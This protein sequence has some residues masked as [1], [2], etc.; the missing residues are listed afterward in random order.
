MK[1]TTPNLMAADTGVQELTPPNSNG[2][3]IPTLSGVTGTWSFKLVLQSY[4]DSGTQDPVRIFA[5]LS[6]TLIFVDGDDYAIHGVK[7][8]NA[9]N[10]NA[11]VILPSTFTTNWG[12]T[13]QQWTATNGNPFLGSFMVLNSSLSVGA[14]AQRITSVTSES[15]TSA[16]YLNQLNWGDSP[17]DTDDGAIQVWDGSA[18]EYTDFSGDWQ[19][20]TITPP[21]PP[22][23][24]YSLT[25][26]LLKQYLDGQSFHVYKMNARITLSVNNKYNTDASGSRPKYINPI[27]RINDVDGKSYVFLRGTFT[28]GDDTWDGEWFN[29]GEDTPTITTTAVDL[30]MSDTPSREDVL[31]GMKLSGSNVGVRGISANLVITTLSER[32]AATDVVTNG[33][34]IG[35]TSWTKGSGVTIGDDQLKFESVASGIGALNATTVSVGIEYFVKFT[36]S[37]Y[38]SGGIQVKLGEALGTAVTANGDYTQNITATT[39]TTI[40]IIASE[41]DTTLNVDGI[42]I[43]ARTKSIKIEDIGETLLADGYKIALIEPVNGNIYD[44]T[45]D[46]AQ[47]SGDTSLTIEAYDFEYP[48]EEGAVITFDTKNLVKEYQDDTL[49]EVCDNGDTTT[50]D[51]KLN[52]GNLGIGTTSPSLPLHVVANE[53]KWVA[54]SSLMNWYLQPAANK[55]FNF[56]NLTQNADFQFKQ[57]VGGSAGTSTLVIK[58]DTGNVGIGTTAPTQKL[59]VNGYIAATRFINPASTLSYLQFDSQ[60]MKLRGTALIYLS[61]AGSEQFRVQDGK[62][63]IGTT[64]PLSELHIKN[65]SAISAAYNDAQLIIEGYDKSVLQMA[66][67]A[68]GY[69]QLVFGD[70]DDGNRGGFLYNNNGDYLVIETNNSEVIRI[71]SSLNVGIGTTDPASKIHINGAATLT[72]MAAPSDPAANDCVIWLD[73][74][75]LDLMVKIKGEA[76][77]VTR[78]IASFS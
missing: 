41:S 52:G 72:A 67:G 8:A 9:V 30:N 10:P 44:L 17:M 15:D 27:G 3:Q 59:E 76:S 50:T 16:L 23:T 7:W 6:N 11:G 51:I 75:S 26:L 56:Y 58:G 1:L 5:P 12:M 49:Q 42:I 55:D 46:A 69:C 73:S 35:D 4:P 65:G 64:A 2:G 36:V 32:I 14:F 45:L 19:V 77:T 53:T 22:A 28:T 37:S 63:G 13:T 74:T 68:S 33:Q 62:V 40:N 39:S 60:N 25:E 31:P 21:T 38:S 24:S 34:F 66:S 71:N 54:A 78:T 70:G 20:G 43:I 57:N 18:W 61:Q 48:V 47:T 29:I